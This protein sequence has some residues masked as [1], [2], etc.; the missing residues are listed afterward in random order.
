M[1][2]RVKVKK[3]EIGDIYMNPVM[4]DLW[5]L[6]KEYNEE[7]KKDVWVLQLVHDSYYEE[8]ENVVGFIKMGNIYQMLNKNIEAIDKLYCWGEALPPD[9]QKE[10]LELLGEKF[11]NE[12]TK[13]R[14]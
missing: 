14:D 2:D 11:Y 3:K 9:F 7:K 1:V 12:T 10:M 5:F 8:L 13:I 6:R 4:M